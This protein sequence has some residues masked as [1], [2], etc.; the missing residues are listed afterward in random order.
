MS[1][2][3]FSPSPGSCLLSSAAQQGNNREQPF[4]PLHPP[5][6]PLPGRC[7]SSKNFKSKLEAGQLLLRDL[8]C[9]LTPH[10][11]LRKNFL[12][13]SSSSPGNCLSAPQWDVFLPTCTALFHGPNARLLM[14][15]NPQRAGHLIFQAL[16]TSYM[17]KDVAEKQEI[18]LRNQ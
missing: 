9:K 7:K 3:R 2:P 5:P 10:K 17:K 14:Y 16:L 11:L 4:P 8:I 13:F 15:D 12:V 18:T 1:G 6:L